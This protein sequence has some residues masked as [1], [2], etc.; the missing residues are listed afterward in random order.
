M[1]T[2]VPKKGRAIRRVCM[3]AAL[4]AL[5]AVAQAQTKPCSQPTPIRLQAFEGSVINMQAIVA[6]KQGFLQ[7]HCLS[8]SLVPI[9]NTPLAVTATMNGTLDVINAGADNIVAARAQG[10]KLKIVANV[11]DRAIDRKSVV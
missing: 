6:M 8:G 3:A 9:A 2:S 11:A 5:M 7:K 10:I 4:T 1:K